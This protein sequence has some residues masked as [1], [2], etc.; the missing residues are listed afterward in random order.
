M[1]AWYKIVGR[2]SVQLLLNYLLMQHTANTNPNTSS[3]SSVYSAQGQV[4]NGKRR[5]QG[6]SSTEGRSGSKVVV[7]PGMNRCGSF[8]LLSVPHFLFSIWTDLKRSQETPLWKWGEWIWL[9]GPSELHRNSS[10]GLNISSIS[11]FFTRS[12]I[13][14]SQSRICIFEA[15]G[16]VNISGHWRR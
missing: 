16:R 13:R 11:V 12:E 7:L 8:P 10:Q 15:L 9:S 14:K 6:C 3:S 5:I 4:L 1:T 2:A